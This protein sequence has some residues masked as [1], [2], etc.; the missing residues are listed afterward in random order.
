MTDEE[1]HELDEPVIEKLSLADRI[2]RDKTARSRRR[3]RKQALEL[4]SY[5]EEKDARQR[6]TAKK[7]LEKQKRRTKKK[8][9]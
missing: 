3:E 7:L 2:A 5:K 8:L 4:H 6:L 9:G 1:I